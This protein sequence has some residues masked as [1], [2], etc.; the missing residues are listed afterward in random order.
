MFTASIYLIYFFW[1]VFN[2]CWTIL[3][4]LMG[5]YVYVYIQ[6]HFLLLPLLLLSCFSCVRLCAT[7]EMAAHQDPLSLGFSRQ[8]CFYKPLPLHWA[9]AVLWNSPFSPFFLSSSVFTLFSFFIILIFWTYYIFLYL[10]LCLPFLL[11]F[12]PCS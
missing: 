4:L 11:F 8:Y 12:S 5:V 10:F 7:P 1:T 9:F 3:T 2:F 6:S